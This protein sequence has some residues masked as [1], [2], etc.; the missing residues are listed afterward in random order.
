MTISKLNSSEPAIEYFKVP[1]TFD[2]G[3][4]PMLT[5]SIS[6]PRRDMASR[7]SILSEILIHKISMTDR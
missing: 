7:A 2:L 4:P 5:Q 1:Y 6:C 3:I